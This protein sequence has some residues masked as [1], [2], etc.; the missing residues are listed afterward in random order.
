[1]LSY[2]PTHLT[3]GQRVR[4][5]RLLDTLILKK[6]LEASGDDGSFRAV[7]S[8]GLVMWIGKPYFGID[9][10]IVQVY[11]YKDKLNVYYTSD[12]LLAQVIPPGF[13]RIRRNVM[14]VK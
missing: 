10:W 12:E 1:M 2:T 7:D 6:W 14:V 4:V 11:H 13:K 3:V 5:W 9:G 8:V